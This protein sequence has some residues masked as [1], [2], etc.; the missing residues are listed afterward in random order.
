LD[1]HHESLMSSLLAKQTTME[2]HD[3]QDGM[4]VEPNHVYIRPPGKDITIKN[5]TLH[6]VKAKEKEETY[7]LPT[8]TFFRSVSE[9][10]KE[11]AIGIILS[12]ASADGTLGAK[13]IK[14][15]GGM[16]MAQDDQEA[17]YSRMP[18]SVIDAR[19]ADFIL[20]AEDMPEQL[21]RYAGHPLMIHEPEALEEENFERSIQKILMIVRTSTGH[22]FSQ[23]KRN[24]IRRRIERRMALHQIHEAQNYARYLRQDPQE[25][26]D[27]FKDLT[28]NV[29]SFF[30]DP[31]AFLHLKEKVVIPMLREMHADST[32]R[33]WVPACA[34]G[35]EA[36]SLAILMTETAE[37]LEKYF[38][39][40]VFATDINTE[41]IETARSGFFPDNIAA[42]LS[43]ERL[44]RFFSKKSQKYQVDSKIRDMVVFAL[45][46]V[47]RDP[48]F[49][50][51]DLVSCRNLLIYMDTNLQKRVLPILH[52]ALKPGGILFLGT[53]E[54][55]GEASELFD[56]LD[57]RNK[58][59]RARPME[60]ERMHRFR[61]PPIL[62]LEE[63]QDQG[64]GQGGQGIPKSEKREQVR[65]VVER[66]IVEKYASPAVLVD[67]SANILYFHGN[68]GRFLSPPIGEAN[69]NILNM[70]S[71]ELHFRL[72]QGFEE[73]KRSKEGL[74]IKD[75]QIRHNDDFFP[76]EV[77]LSPLSL[78]RKRSWILVEFK[79]QERKAQGAKSKL[80]Q[81]EDDEEK[82]A[83]RL[84][85][86]EQKLKSS[87]HELQAT[88]EE[89]ETSNEELRSANEEL[90]ANNE[91][92]QSTNEE[93]ESSKEELQ[94]TNEELETVN[95]ELSKKNQDLTKAEDDLNNLFASNEVGT[96]FLDDE[97]CIKRFTPAAKEVFNLKEKVDIG[98][99]ISDITSNLNYEALD[100][101]AKEVLD[102]LTRKEIK[103]TGKDGKAYIVRITP[104][105]TNTN[106]IE[107]VIITFLDVTDLEKM[108]S[109]AK[110]ADALFY[111]TMSALWDPVLVLDQE[112]KV[113]MA[114]R[115]FYRTFKTSPN[116]TLSRSI[117]ELGGQQWDIPELRRF[118]EDIIPMDKEFEG[119]EVEHD[120]L[121]IGRRKMSLNARK[122]EGG[123][124]RFEMILLVFRDVTGKQ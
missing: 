58:I 24:T 44:R 36:Y 23:Y 29:T 115:A 76:L 31:V 52:Y 112:Y 57:K 99:R 55:V 7:R 49:S 22:D 28:I 1:P 60:M 74:S 11:R 30:R 32:V 5:L 47:A 91:E 116:E 75:I 114:N 98:R 53:S 86:L 25:V 77:S 118:L 96:I 59:Y 21:L 105:R 72:S 56:I 94:S 2:V 106:V 35:E 97:L 113:F 117:F 17:E 15:E 78:A 79:E 104:Y 93:L 27:L 120:F 38:Q 45:H 122:I 16:V 18:R 107:G 39:F 82:K 51:L 46:D 92:L 4:P 63:I 41:A 73:V 95:A 65:E 69:L 8:D 40:K 43:E 71:G 33:V 3:A 110:N 109:T 37:E 108:E 62:F 83:P 100:S 85:E 66:A 88:I 81:E 42:D 123:E 121:S 61:M 84:V 70:V 64:T 34:T 90:Q 119:Y 102:K 10:V 101:D 111:D 26:T 48:P 80:S 68:T 19:L 14:G 87:Q 20:P 124:G 6:L 89:L 12:G 13:V 103:V 67:E 54:T 50:N 9:D